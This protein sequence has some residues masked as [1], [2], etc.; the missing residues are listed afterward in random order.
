M[1]NKNA[2]GKTSDTKFR[3]SED[4]FNAYCNVAKNTIEIGKEIFTLESLIHELCEIDTSIIIESVLNEKNSE[5]FIDSHSEHI[6]FWNYLSHFIS[7]FGEFSFIN[8]SL[9]SYGE[10]PKHEEF[11]I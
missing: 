1:E 10:K 2:V 6:R 8:P 9:Y 11:L 4:R 3:F 5:I 7:P